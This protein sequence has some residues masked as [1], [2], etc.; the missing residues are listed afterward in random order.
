M[1]R[2]RPQ[3]VDDRLRT[4]F[5]ADLIHLEGVLF[6]AGNFDALVRP[7]LALADSTISGK[8]VLQQP[9]VVE[10]A[11]DYGIHPESRGAEA[12]LCALLAVQVL[13]H[14]G[15]QG[16]DLINLVFPR[17]GCLHALLHRV[18][19]L[20][21]LLIHVNLGLLLILLHIIQLLLETRELLLFLWLHR[22]P[23]LPF[24]LVDAVV[25][26][27]PL[28]SVAFELRVKLRASAFH[29]LGAKGAPER[30]REPFPL[31]LVVRRDDVQEAGADEAEDGHVEPDRSVGDCNLPQLS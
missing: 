9:P 7:V 18:L 21:H 14:T 4:S 16:H 8:L 20:F 22:R 3:L 12:A 5:P 6:A 11:E 15:H 26:A 2:R 30:A 29:A 17:L 19:E 1:I 31:E 23:D 27:L 25:Q 24:D 13:A 28:R 10:R